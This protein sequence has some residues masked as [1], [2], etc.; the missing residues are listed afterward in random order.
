MLVAT[1]A[2]RYSITYDKYISEWNIS[3][4][5]MYTYTTVYFHNVSERFINFLKTL[6]S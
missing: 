6:T 5:F 1:N 4:V 2:A 3:P